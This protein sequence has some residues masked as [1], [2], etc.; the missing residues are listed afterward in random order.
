VVKSLSEIIISGA[1]F[2]I[3]TPQLQAY[4]VTDEVISVKPE[5]SN[6]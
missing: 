5:I 2:E 1:S 3:E 6:K 4:N